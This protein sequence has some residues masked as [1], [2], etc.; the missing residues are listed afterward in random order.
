MAPEVVREH[1]SH[2]ADVWSAGIVAYLLLTGRLPYPFWE[3][4][5]VTK[6]VG[7]CGRSKHQW[8]RAGGQP[9]ARLV[10]VTVSAPPAVC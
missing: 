4:L 8:Q 2:P 6:E 9:D 7:G 5:Y 10:A 1:Y 3:K